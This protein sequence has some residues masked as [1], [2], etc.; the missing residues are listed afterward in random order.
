MIA[1][2][3]VILVIQNLIPSAKAQLRGSGGYRQLCGKI[4][5]WIREMYDAG[6]EGVAS[7]LPA[8][9][10]SR[11]PNGLCRA[12]QPRSNYSVPSDGRPHPLGLALP[13]AQLSVDAV[14]RD[15]LLVL[16]CNSQPEFNYSN[17]N[18]N[19]GPFPEYG[20]LQW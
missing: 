2:A 3:L 1:A 4:N 6:A 13:P 14:H 5:G 18:S 17:S 8:K 12:H 11:I 7:P 15:Q 16:N 9:R 19:M 10:K 20:V